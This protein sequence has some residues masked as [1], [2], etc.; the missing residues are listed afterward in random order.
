MSQMK[1]N[2]KVLRFPLTADDLRRAGDAARHD[3]RRA[4]RI[5][6]R[7][8]VAI[9]VAVIAILTPRIAKWVDSF[10]AAHEKPKEPEDPRMK[11]VRGPYDMPEPEDEKKE[12]ETE[13]GE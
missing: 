12:Q 1:A 10:R 11:M 8:L 7:A 2:E 5:Q 13:S 9:V 3:A 6:R 4:K